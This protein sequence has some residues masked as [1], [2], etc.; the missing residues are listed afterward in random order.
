M[1]EDLKN[2]WND[3]DFKNYE[4]LEINKNV[5]KEKKNI[6]INMNINEKID[7]ES[8]NTFTFLIS[9]I[10]FHVLCFVLIILKPTANIIFIVT[11]IAGFNFFAT[12]LYSITNIVM[13]DFKKD[14]NKIIWL[15]L[16]I[17][18]PISC[19]V[20]PYASRNQKEDN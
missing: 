18:I 8:E 17:V 15:I 5:K 2:F 4:N 20:Y 6:N 7:N 1:S 14:V 13:N 19:F 10:A 12:W 11:A 9:Q 16:I 3:K